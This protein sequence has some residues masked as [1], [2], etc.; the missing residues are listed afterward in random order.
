MTQIIEFKKI[1]NYKKATYTHA[2]MY[3]HAQTTLI[4]IA[5]LEGGRVSDPLCSH[6]RISRTSPSDVRRQ[7]MY[8][9]ALNLEIIIIKI[10]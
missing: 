5:P 9:R 3:T 8:K 4:T 10:I 2:Q 7:V 6:H 1:I